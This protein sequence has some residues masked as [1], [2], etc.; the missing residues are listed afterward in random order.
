MRNNSIKP[1]STKNSLLLRNKLVQA[2]SN[3][4]SNNRNEITPVAKPIVDFGKNP[5]SFNISKATEENDDYR[6]TIWTGENLQATLMNIKEGSDIGLEVHPN[7]DQFIRIEKGSGQVQMG[8]S[9]DNLTYV[10]P[11]FEDS[12]VFIP[13]GTWHNIVNTGNEDLKIYTIYAPPHH[14]K[15]TVHVTREQAEIEG[16]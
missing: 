8:E 4:N 1:N 6:R 7:T 12:A 13:A 5:I 15:G 3:V 16:D 2:N 11:I 9:K 10:Q 14:P